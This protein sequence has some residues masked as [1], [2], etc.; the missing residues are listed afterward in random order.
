[1]NVFVVGFS[2][3]GRADG[4]RAAGALRDLLVRVGFLEPGRVECW[5]APSRTA[6]AA[7]AQHDLAQTAGVR[8]AHREERRLALF[9][10][11]PFRWTGDE[12]T[13][14]RTPLDPA[15]YLPP[16]EEW[17]DALDGRWVAAR[18]DDDARELEVACD[19]MGAYPLYRARDAE[20]TQWF[21]TNAEALRLLAQDDGWDVEVLA[22][23]LAGG[24]SLTGHPWWRAVR[25]VPR[26]TTLRLG[27]GEAES[28]HRQLTEQEVVRLPGA[29]FDAQH[30]GRI[31]VASLAG[32]ADWPGRPNQVP[33]TAGRD[34]RLVLAAALR[35]DFAWEALTAGAPGM[36]DVEKGRGVCEAAGVGH[37]IADFDPHGIMFERPSRAAQVVALTSSGTACV[38]DAAGFPLGPRDGVLPLWH[39]GQGGEVARSYYGTGEGM[40]RGGLVEHLY[41]RFTTRRPGRP[42]LVG[43]EG[44][45]IVR[46]W[47]EGF[48]DEQLGL[49]AQPADVPDLFYFHERLASWAGPSHGCVEWVKDTTSP[50]WSRR[51]LP[52]ELGLP[53]CERALELFHMRVLGELAPELIVVPFEGDRPWPVHQSSAGRRLARARV[54]VRKGLA[55]AR[56]RAP[57]PPGRQ[58]P[59]GSGEPPPPGTTADLDAAPMPADPFDQTMAAVRE[60]GLAEPAHPA[61]D[62]LDRGRIEALLTREPAALDPMSRAYVWRLA[63]V[64]LRK[65]GD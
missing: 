44:A 19:T 16:A 63:T 37:R 1:M 58:R 21:A 8:Y 36:E 23:L 42:E 34:S 46:G 49:G 20:G 54:L 61:W 43:V 52:H 38:A 35:A 26:G 51:L 40:D 64:F 27:A 57:G 10:G 60:A 45:R 32:L 9:S 39:S 24:F 6:A 53:A 28:A 2:E 14:G 15:F 22:S 47:M 62:V 3:A 65:G 33:I 56:R 55:E 25:R 11:R 29:G 17:V 59:G 5:T 4:K 50:I 13:E 18:Y 41:R 30:A 12:T 48:V 7:W 31:L